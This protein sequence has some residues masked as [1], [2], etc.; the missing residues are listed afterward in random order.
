MQT[1]QD[2][3]ISRPS[4]DWLALAIG[5]VALLTSVFDHVAVAQA[6]AGVGGILAGVSG[7]LW[8]SYTGSSGE[9][10]AALRA[11]HGEQIRRNWQS[12]NLG[13]VAATFVALLTVAISGRLGLGLLLAASAYMLAKA[14]RASV[15][16][17]YI[18][19]I[20]DADAAPRLELQR[21][22]ARH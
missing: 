7:L 13:I 3:W 22:S 2:A 6:T 19:K 4:W 20:I 17:G 12:V 1:V 15:L 14:I 16:M 5:L 10:M 11:S 21:D 18:G 9:R 8:S